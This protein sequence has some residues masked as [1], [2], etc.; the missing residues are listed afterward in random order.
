MAIF[1][2]GELVVIV[3]PLE[4]GDNIPAIVLDP[5]VTQE[6]LSPPSVAHRQ[7][8][9]LSNGKIQHIRSDFLGKLII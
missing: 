6:G 7:V 2:K 8:K 3:V 9:I 1:K 5:N 4:A